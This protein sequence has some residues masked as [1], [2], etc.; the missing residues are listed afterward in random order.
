MASS[1]ALPRPRKPAMMSVP[2]IGTTGGSEA[3]GMSSRSLSVDMIAN[4][5]IDQLQQAPGDEADQRGLQRYPPA[6]RI[7][8]VLRQSRMNKG[9]KID[10]LLARH[11]FC[12]QQEH[13]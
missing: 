4:A 6:Q 3:A 7:E 13:Q 10:R 1:P 2:S 11:V 12:V 5:V 8:R 9:G